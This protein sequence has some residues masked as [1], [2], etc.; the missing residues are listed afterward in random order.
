MKE[1]NSEIR[2][3]EHN[4]DKHNHELKAYN[5]LLQRHMNEDRVRSERTSIFLASNSIL[6]IG[7]IMLVLENRLF[8]PIV[9]CALGIIISFITLPLN[10]GSWKAQSAWNRGE[11]KIEISAQNPVFIYMKRME[12]LPCSQLDPAA[13]HKE[14]GDWYVKLKH[15]RSQPVLVPLLFLGLWLVSLSYLVIPGSKV[16]F[17]GLSMQ[18]VQPIL[19]EGW[20]VTISLQYYLFWCMILTLTVRFVIC[21]FRAWAMGTGEHLDKEDKTPI[22]ERSYIKRYFQAFSGFTGH[23]NIRDYWLPAIIGFSEVACY[24]V[25]IFLNQTVFI[26]WWLAL[27]T[28]GNWKVFEKSRTAFYRFLLGN[29]L[30]LGVSFFWMLR[31]ISK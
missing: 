18:A 25:L 8:L 23:K 26:G 28:A 15:W 31:F 30:I 20:R 1:E 3:Q 4:I 9:I 13:S 10:V 19:A 14:R 21:F 7:F 22:S 2:D 5:I 17:G 27:K 6:Y 29:L 24:P 16:Y 12:I 11:S